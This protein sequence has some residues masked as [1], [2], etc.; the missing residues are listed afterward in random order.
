MRKTVFIS[1]ILILVRPVVLIIFVLFEE[2]GKASDETERFFFEFQFQF[3]FQLGF[4]G[5]LQ[6]APL[7]QNKIKG[8]VG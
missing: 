7:N 1:V 4:S 6:G 3:Q 2:R 8:E 5:P